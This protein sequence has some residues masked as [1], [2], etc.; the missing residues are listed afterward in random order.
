MVSKKKID[1][2]WFE[3][4]DEGDSP[5]FAEQLAG[6]FKRRGYDARV[7]ITRFEPPT[8]EEFNFWA[9]WIKP[10]ERRK[11]PYGNRDEIKYVLETEQSKYAEKFK[12]MM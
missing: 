9:V 2:G 1:G 11:Y 12:K 7:S 6:A 3:K 4:V 10:K 5:A 8:G